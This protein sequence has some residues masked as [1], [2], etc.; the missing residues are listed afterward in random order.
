M[1]EIQHGRNA[2][3]AKAV[4][5]TEKAIAIVGKLSRVNALRAAD[6]DLPTEL[7]KE[8]AEYIR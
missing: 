2:I 3:K 6:K 4:E 5:F 8:K 1:V 7:E